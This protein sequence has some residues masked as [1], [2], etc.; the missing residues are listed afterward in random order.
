M[1]YQGQMTQKGC[2]CYYCVGPNTNK[3]ALKAV[4]HRGRQQDRK[5]EKNELR[6]VKPR[7]K[8]EV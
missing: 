1:K 2:Q 4:K 8:E 3:S 5:V 7:R 6:L